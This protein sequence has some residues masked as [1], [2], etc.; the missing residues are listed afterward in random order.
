MA[1]MNLARSPAVRMSNTSGL[2]TPLTPSFPVVVVHPTD[3]QPLVR[4][5]CIV[6][7]AVAVVVSELPAAAVVFAVSAAAARIAGSI[8]PCSATMKT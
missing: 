8:V 5:V 3:T 1:T 2:P 4:I 6:V 7:A